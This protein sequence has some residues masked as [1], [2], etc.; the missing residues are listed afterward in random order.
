MA[1]VGFGLGKFRG[2]GGARDLAEALARKYTSGRRVNNSAGQL[3]TLLSLLPP[4]TQP[5]GTI[6]YL[7][8]R[9]A[10]NLGT[11]SDIAS[12]DLSILEE[13]PTALL[14]DALRPTYDKKAKAFFVPGLSSLEKRGEVLL[15][16][17]TRGPFPISKV[18]YTLGSK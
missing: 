17:G 9:S 8:S 4:E 6:S 16:F 14:P 13:S 5:L 7:L 18:S 15:A 11:A 1:S 3:A 2:P 12:V 10:A